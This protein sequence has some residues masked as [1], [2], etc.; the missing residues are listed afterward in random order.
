MEPFVR[1]D[2]SMAEITLEERVKVLEVEL[3]EVKKLL[4]KEQPAEQV[5]WWRQISGIFKDDPM[6]DEA[7]RLGREWRESETDEP[8]DEEQNIAMNKHVSA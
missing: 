1:E 3:A 5:P 2:E 8:A 6:F 4:R 7:M